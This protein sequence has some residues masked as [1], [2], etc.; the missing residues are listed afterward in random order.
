MQDKQKTF[1]LLDEWVPHSKNMKRDEALA[2]LAE[3]YFRSHGPATLQDFVWWSGLPMANAR[4]GLDIA[5]TRLHQETVDGQSYCLP[6]NHSIPKDSSPTA[7]LLPAF[8][9]YYLGYKARNAVLDSKYD[10]QAV[11]S[12]GVFRPMLVID[13]QVVGIW[14]R[15]LKKDSVIITPDPFKSLTEAENQALLAA[16]NQYGAFLGLPVVLAK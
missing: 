1:V 12:S 9:E 2:E 13:G 8:D 6:Q 7:Y 3:R 11:S 16:A 15:T 10:K 14:K 4:A 5:K